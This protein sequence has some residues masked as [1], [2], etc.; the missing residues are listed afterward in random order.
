MYYLC[1]MKKLYCIL[2]LFC[3]INSNAQINLIPNPSF[4]EDTACPT[5]ISQIYKLKDWYSVN[6]T[7][8][9]FNKCYNN[10]ANNNALIPSNAFG[11]QNVNNGCHSYVGINHFG[12]GINSTNNELIGVK[13]ISSLT[14]GTKYYLSMKV[15]LANRSRKSGNNLGATFHLNKPPY[16]FTISP[17]NFA[18]ITF[19]QTPVDT[20]SWVTLFSSF[21]SNNNF[22][23]ITIGNFYDTLSFNRIDLY[24]EVSPN[25]Y[26]YLDDICLTTDSAFA[27][28]Y[29]FNC[30]LTNL[31]KNDINSIQLI[32]NPAQ[33]KIF[34]LTDKAIED[35]RLYDLNGNPQLFNRRDYEIEFNLPQGLYI[36]RLKCDGNFEY[37]KI[38]IHN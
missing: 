24:N 4:E 6:T 9:Y 37:K 10:T 15:S 22:E 1:Y 19:S 21:T 14:T 20:N 8:D 23:Y 38:I 11:Y 28:N 2:L 31:T 16:T 25:I 34:L 3:F 27:Y 17:T 7:P 26:F 35:V 13:L 5:Q 29:N 18:H 36:L 12:Y 30:L 32:P 33:N